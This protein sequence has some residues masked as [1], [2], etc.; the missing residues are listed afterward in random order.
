MS[1]VE[2]ADAIV[3]GARCA[4]A[5]A[6]TALARAGRRVIAVDRAGFPSDTLSTHLLFAG[7]VA[8][9]RALGALGRVEEI[10]APRMPVATVN[11]AGITVQGGYTPVGGVDWALCV[12]RTGLDAALVET[13][14]DAGAEVRERTKATELL[15]EGGRVAGVRVEGPDGGDE[16]RAPLVVG[17]DGR[18]SWLARELGVTEPY[19]SNANQRACAFAYW[20]D[21]DTDLRHI[22]SQWREGPELGTA[23]PCDDGEV[24]VLLMPPLERAGAFRDDPI[25]EYERTIERMPGLRDRLA[26]CERATKVRVA[27]DLLSYFRRSAG[28]GWALA[29][30]AGHFKDPITAQGI[31]DA[32]RYGRRL[33]EI[34]APAIGDPA[35]LDRALQAWER[36]RE[37]ECIEAYQWTNKVARAESMSPV[38]VELYREYAGRPDGARKLLD[39][40]SRTLPPSEAFS[41]GEGMR[42]ALRALR[43]P[44]ADRR[45]VVRAVARELRDEVRDRRVRRAVAAGEWASGRLAHRRGLRDRGAQRLAQ[46]SCLADAVDVLVGLRAEDR[47]EAEL[48][49]LGRAAVGV[50]DVAELARQAELS[51]AGERLVAGAA[52]RLAAMG[53]DEREGDGEV[54]AGLVDAHAARDVHED[55]VGAERGAAVTG[56]HRE[57]EREP[58]AVDP[59]RHPARRH[60]LGR[61]HEGLDLDQ[62][63]PGP[64]H[65]AEHHGP[66]RGRGLRREAGGRIRDLGEAAGAHLEDADLA[67]RAEAVL[68]RAQ[69]PVRALALALEQEHAVDQVLEHARAGDRALLGDVADEDDGAPD[70]L[71]HLHHLVGRLAD[72][73]DRAGRACEVGRVKRLDRVDHARVGALRF[74]RGQDALQRGLGD[75]RHRERA[76]PEPL[77]AEAHLRGR[78]LAGDV[79]R[80]PARGLEVPERHP[81]EGRL[82]DPGRAAEQD[83]RPGHEATAEHPVE[84]SDPRQQPLGARQLDLAERR[85]PR[86]LRPAAAA[87]SPTP[88]RRRRLRRLLDE[89]VPLAAPGAAARPGERLVRALLADVGAASLRHRLEGM[90]P[91]GRHR[92]PARPRPA[93]SRGARNGG[94]IGYGRALM[95]MGGVRPRALCAALTAALALTAAA[96]AI[97]FDPEAER[98]NY[99][100]TLERDRYIVKT[101]EFQ[102]RLAEQEVQDN[103]DL[104]AIAS[105]E[106]PALATQDQR[107]FLGNVCSNRKRECAGDV[108]FYDWKATVPGAVVEPVLFTGR[109]GATLSGNVWAVEP[110]PSARPAIVITTGSVQAPETLYWGLAAFLAQRGYVV[111][112]YDVQGQGRSDTL[113]QGPD[114]DEGVPAQQPANFVDGTE[115]ALDFMLSTPGEPYAP[116]PSCA[117]GTSHE[118]RHLTRVGLGLNAPFNPLHA[119]VDP[120]RVGIAGHSLGASA[121]SF[122]GQKDPRVDAV[123]AWDNLGG[124]AKRSDCDSAPETRADAAITKPALGISND[125]GL[126]P[127][128]HTSDPDPQGKSGGFEALRAAGAD[129]MQVNVRGGTHFESSFIPGQTVPPLGQA[130]L[131]GYDLVAWYTAAWFDKYVRCAGDA[132]CAAQ[133]DRELLTTRWQADLRNGEV[134][135]AGDPNLYSFYFRSRYALTTA[136][137]SPVSCEDMRAGCA[138]MAFDGGPQ[139]FSLLGT[140]FGSADGGGTA[141]APSSPPPACALGQGGGRGRDTLIGTDAGDALRAGGG[142]DR[143]RGL[144]GDDCLFGQAGDD[145]LR[146]GGG[147][148]RLRGGKGDDR[149]NAVDGEPDVVNCGGGRGDVALV[150]RRDEG[151]A[152]C[153]R[154][155]GPGA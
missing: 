93:I 79:E 105:D 15:L 85:R 128:P 111:L 20:R 5:A 112:T 142:P 102:L 146:G 87:A 127:T 56:E 37:R 80:L 130:T 104:A 13:A 78:L 123:V 96:P 31:R 21:R 16:L 47:R 33:G 9:L 54:G 68:E 39:V 153:E 29:G 41:L 140:A 1:A 81:G 67:G 122:V 6:A 2:T 24:L 58:V 40:F 17:A 117:S 28:P 42:M 48:E 143:V 154:V 60:D 83:Q 137:G 34:A 46:R 18:K 147:R 72:L 57:D 133:A 23:F 61:R 77:G 26:G 132:T 145:R 66:R 12:R 35:A 89:R 84:L 64:L 75:R 95:P 92:A 53:G 43:R 30:D 139:A 138:T 32:L 108:R 101:P 119:L 106:V 155:R 151:A 88:L 8:E 90:K 121:V 125:Y 14:R 98:L 38:E 116:R 49:C 50:R 27:T 25:A 141:A 91:G 11:G 115:D 126:T 71:R 51:E 94:W 109:S 52:Q 99:Q 114:E 59:G 136:G 4:G 97:A 149:L 44:G 134:D 120:G 69:G 144:A 76:L 45:G 36:E 110:G 100:K 82:A 150:D 118:P 63:R 22:A 135:A 113:G 3:V 62:E 19:R 74:E 103:A 86:R 148:D 107:N 10:G 131:R 70:P 7:G 129:S 124:A 65:R 55:V 152:G 73:G